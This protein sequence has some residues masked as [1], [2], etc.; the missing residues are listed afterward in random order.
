MSGFNPSHYVMANDQ[1]VAS[2]LPIGNGRP[3]SPRRFLAYW[4][5]TADRLRPPRIE[6]ATAR[7]ACAAAM[8]WAK[9]HFNDLQVV[10]R[11][12]A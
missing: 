4:S 8:Q 9:Q 5:I 1:L 12:R 3:G 6:C 11:I 10:R 7:E 2:V